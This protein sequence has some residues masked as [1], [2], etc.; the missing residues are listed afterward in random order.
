[1][2]GELIDNCMCQVTSHWSL[3]S[4]PGHVAWVRGWLEFS[5]NCRK[6]HPS[7]A[8]LDWWSNTSVRQ[9]VEHTHPPFYLTITGSNQTWG[10]RFFTSSSMSCK[11]KCNHVPTIQS[12][13]FRSYLQS[14]WTCSAN[15]LRWKE[16]VSHSQTLAGKSLATQDCSADV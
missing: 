12:N 4:Y 16:T 13:W 8:Q 11:F 6:A 3:A 7:W 15:R 14:T 5:W 9:V 10:E 2:G 1:M